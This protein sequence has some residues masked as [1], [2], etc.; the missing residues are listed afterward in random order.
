MAEAAE[1]WSDASLPD[2]VDNDETK[3]KLQQL[4]SATSDFSELVKAG[5]PQE[6]GNSLTELHDLFHELQ[7][8]WYGAAGDHEEHH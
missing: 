7:E 5:N 4:K 2:N 6:I 3:A 8:D 1:R